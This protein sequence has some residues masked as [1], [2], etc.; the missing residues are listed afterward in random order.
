MT[1]QTNFGQFGS[2]K[3][4]DE[5]KYLPVLPKSQKASPGLPSTKTVNQAY[6]DLVHLESKMKQRLDKNLSERQHIRANL[7][8]VIDTLADDTLLQQHKEEIRYQIVK[9]EIDHLQQDLNAF[10]TSTQTR[11]EEQ[12]YSSVYR[13]QSR[14]KNVQKMGITVFGLDEH[15]VQ[16]TDK[17]LFV[18]ND[19]ARHRKI[20]KR[21]LS[22]AKSYYLSPR[23][24]TK[25]IL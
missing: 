20:Q 6:Q 9:R 11:H 5:S 17:L 10:I 22:E 13:H 2:N 4:L 3:R 18:E 14:L 21:R 23:R 16:S 15:V 12:I 7:Q 24:P 1:S 25:Q 19:R 8:Q